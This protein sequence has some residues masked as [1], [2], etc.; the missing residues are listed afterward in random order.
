[1]LNKGIS[2]KEIQKLNHNIRILAGHKGHLMRIY[3]TQLE[4]Q[5]KSLLDEY[6]V[7]YDFHRVF[8]QLDKSKHKLIEHYYIADFWLPDKKLVLSIEDCTRKID[9]KNDNYRTSNLDNYRLQHTLISIR[10]DDLRNGNFLR[11]FLLLVK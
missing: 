2:K 7:K 5:I 4:S 10:R 9:I 3:P 11:D 6:S 8:Y 1:M